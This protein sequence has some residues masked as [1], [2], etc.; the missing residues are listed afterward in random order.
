M[1]TLEF[2]PWR[3][4][5]RINALNTV[6]SRETSLQNAIEKFYCLLNYI[7]EYCIDAQWITVA[8]LNNS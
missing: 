8:R 1:E 3:N 5:E 7:F 2:R 6:F 4:Q